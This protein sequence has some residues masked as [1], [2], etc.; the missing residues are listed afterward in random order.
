MIL[1]CNLFFETMKFENIKL[2]IQAQRLFP[3]ASLKE[4]RETKI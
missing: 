3:T 2:N 1:L 4:R